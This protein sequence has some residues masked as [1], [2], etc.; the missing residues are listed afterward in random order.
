MAALCAAGCAT[1]PEPPAHIPILAWGSIPHGENETLERYQELKEAGFDYTFTRWTASYDEVCRQLDL[2]AAVGVKAFVHCPELQESPEETVSKLKDHPGLGGWF[3]RDEPENDAMEELGAWARRIESVDTVHPCYLNLLPSYCF[4]PE[5]YETHLHLFTER[6]ALPQIS[7]DNYPVFYS[8]KDGDG[9]AEV[10]LNPLWYQ[11]LEMVSA[12]ARRAGVPFWAFALSTAHTNIGL[13]QFY[14][15]TPA[16]PIPTIDHLRIQMYSNLA[17]GAQLLQYFSYWYGDAVNPLEAPISAGRRTPDYERIRQMNEEIQCRAFVWAGCTVESVCHLAEDSIPMG[18]KPL[19]DLPAHFRKLEIEKGRSLVS[20][21]K[22][23]QHRYV[24]LVNTS[25]V[26]EC[27][28]R[29]ET[30]EKV[31]L[32]RRDGS[33]VR[34]T[35]YDSLF[36]LTPGDCAIFELDK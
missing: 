8:D 16:Y 17:Y 4:T 18:T 36:I 27:Q 6:V 29:V 31:Q 26:D 1:K 14:T 12:E 13:A 2:C 7:F 34:A 35:L 23:G 5:E 21:I 3:L 9:Q 20:V 32:V 28:M 11:N 33:R 24:M 10:H 19:I 22:N 30:D 15:P 25:P